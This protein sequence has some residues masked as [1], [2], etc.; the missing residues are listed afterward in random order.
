MLA[1]WFGL[2]MVK[3]RAKAVVTWCAGRLPLWQPV[4]LVMEASHNIGQQKA[5]GDEK[6]INKV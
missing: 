4:W 2:S 3:E 6:Q 1:A 5:K